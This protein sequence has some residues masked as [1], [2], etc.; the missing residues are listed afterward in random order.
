MGL[1]VCFQRKWFFYTNTP[2]VKQSSFSLSS[3]IGAR[4]LWLAWKLFILHRISIEKE[5]LF[6]FN[7]MKSSG[8][9]HQNWLLKWK[10]KLY[11][12]IL[13]KIQHAI[14]KANQ[15]STYQHQVEMSYRLFLQKVVLSGDENS[16]LRL[17]KLFADSIF[18]SAGIE[19]KSVK[20]ALKLNQDYN[21]IVLLLI[22]VRLTRCNFYPIL[23]LKWIFCSVFVDYVAKHH[24][25]Q[26]VLREKSPTFLWK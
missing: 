13:Q 1:Q 22:W 21:F 3:S 4:N 14:F 18:Y 26:F 15:L 11:P 23:G 24:L 5:K 17:E 9:H 8:L 16:I 10:K 20:S 6:S 7:W 2:Q 25:L 19:V 12:K